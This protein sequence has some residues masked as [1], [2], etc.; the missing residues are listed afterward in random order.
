MKNIKTD[1]SKATKSSA[2]AAVAEK[3]AAISP[4]QTSNV[5]P[6]K[7]AATSMTASRHEVTKDVIAK[8]AYII[9]E[10]Q[11]RPQGHDMAN[12][13]LAEKQ[14]KQEQSFTA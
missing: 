5:A 14:L 10:Q 4:R 3:P 6:Q 1:K 9:W 13:L 2:K 11:G 7:S 12:W 8:R